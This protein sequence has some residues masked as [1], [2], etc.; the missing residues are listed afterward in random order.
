MPPMLF[1]EGMAVGVVVG[2]LLDV[3]VTAF[4]FMRWSQPGRS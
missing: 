2:L 4:L 3:A 1:W